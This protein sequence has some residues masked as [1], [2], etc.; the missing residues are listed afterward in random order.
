[1]VFGLFRCGKR[2]AWR[3][4]PYRRRDH[5]R[6]MANPRRKAVLPKDW[7]SP[8]EP[9]P[10][11]ACNPLNLLESPPYEVPR[12]VQSLAIRSG[13]GGADARVPA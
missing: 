3:V 12:P 7:S 11:F 2:F 4:M 5:A 8:L 13:T 10:R 6:K 9:R 1:L